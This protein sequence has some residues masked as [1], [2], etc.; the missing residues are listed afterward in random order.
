[1]PARYKTSEKGIR[2]IKEFEGEILKV[3]LDPV[4]LPTLGVGHLLTPAE[5]RVY[6]VGQKITREESTR[7]LRDDLT[8]FEDAVNSSV[9]VPLTQ[10]QFD[11]LISFAFNV[12]IAAFKR[13]SV[14]KNLNSRNFA[15]AADAFLLWNKAGG[16]VLPGLARRRKAE[17]ALFLTPDKQNSTLTGSQKEVRTSDITSN[18]PQEPVTAGADFNESENLQK[19]QANSAPQT[20]ASVNQPPDNFEKPIDTASPQAAADAEPI[21]VSQVRPELDALKTEFREESKNQIK[22]R[23]LAIPGIILASLSALWER[24]TAGETM[25]VFW[26]VGAAVLLIVVYI[27]FTK[28]R[29]VQEKR[30]KRDAEALEVQLKLQREQQAHE[31]TK[32][33]LESAMRR[34]VNTVVVRPQPVL[35][36]DAPGEK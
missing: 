35:N 31:L 15:A 10:N 19:I 7:F 24:V 36:S 13:S 5:K 16:R 27:I 18:Y 23:F 11:A 14:V 28:Y 33:Q 26:L 32:I 12:G 3:Y 29:D 17:R 1:M 6:K 21:P 20:E 4:K 25:L 30:L 2:L 8:L 22:S 34:D 9:R